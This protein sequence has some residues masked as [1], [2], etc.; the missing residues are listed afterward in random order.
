MAKVG[1]TELKKH[2]NSLDQKMLEKE[3]IE[4]FKT[5]PQ[6][7]E[8]Y[9]FKLSP[10]QEVEILNKYKNIIEREFDGIKAVNNLRFAVLKKAVSDFEKVSKDPAYLAE[11]FL[12]YVD[13]AMNYTIVSGGMNETLFNNIIKRF[14]K[15]CRLINENNLESDFYE[16]LQ[17]VLEKRK[18]IGWG[19]DLEILEIYYEY[20]DDDHFR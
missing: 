4:L 14:D 5:F 13:C 19:M 1:I 16:P 20:M 2:L 17:K 3:I 8:Y 18:N 12:C 15:A 9:T 7:K 11:L 10:D 6:I